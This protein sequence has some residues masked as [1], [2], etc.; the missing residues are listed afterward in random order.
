MFEE[1][2]AEM[3]KQHRGQSPAD[4]EFNFLYHAR[5]LEGY[6]TVIFEVNTFPPTNKELQTSS[7]YNSNDVVHVGVSA[8]GITLFRN[9]RRVLSYPWCNICKLSFKRKQFLLSVVQTVSSSEQMQNGNHNKT[10]KFIPTTREVVQHENFTLQC[11]KLAR[12]LWQT[13][14][15]YHTFF[16]LK[17]PPISSK[18]TAVSILAPFNLSFRY[19]GRTE[20][21]GLEDMKRKMRTTERPFSRSSFNRF[22]RK[23]VSTTT[24]VCFLYT[25]FR[26]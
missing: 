1:R 11:P 21:Q 14:V 5:N 2:L 4:A 25:I 3:H 15:E 26:Q 12:S 24:V 6:G 22:A 20:F 10:S 8:N 16:R 17:A 9:G 7:G 18:S 13:A 23:T 19:S